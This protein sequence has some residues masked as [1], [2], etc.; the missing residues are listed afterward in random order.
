M[1]K[2]VNNED[3]SII[4]L[5]MSHAESNDDDDVEYMMMMM[6]ITSMTI[7]VITV[8]SIVINITFPARMIVSRLYTFLFYFIIKQL[9][10]N[11]TFLLLRSSHSTELQT[12]RLR[13]LLLRTQGSKML[14]LE[15]VR[16]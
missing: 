9:I 3:D 8:V 12:Q 16:I 13:S 10:N 14:S 2:K 4:V 11:I 7:V 6:M 15:Q 1:T 5:T